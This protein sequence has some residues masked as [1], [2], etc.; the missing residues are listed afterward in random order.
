MDAMHSAI[1][2]RRN[3]LLSD[4][5]VEQAPT[6]PGEPGVGG[7]KPEEMAGLVKMLSNDQKQMLLQMLAKDIQGVNTAEIE[8]EGAPGPGEEMELAEYS[9][10]DEG[11]HESEEEIMES[12]ISSAD[13]SRASNGAKPRNL[14]ERVK[15][16]L[17]SKLKDKKKG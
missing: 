11:G 2:Q 1:K 13:K 14:G 8:Q 5:P 16:N 3:G 10:D 4:A 9:M 12:M 15:M 6:T 17:A 7:S